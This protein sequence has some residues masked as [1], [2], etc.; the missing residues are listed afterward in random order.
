MASTHATLRSGFL[1]SVERYPQRPA[2]EVAGEVLTYEELH[3]RAASL[4]ATIE[5]N[6]PSGGPALTAVL[7][8][9]SAGAFAGVLGALLS[10]RGYVPLNPRFPA[11]RTA[12]MLSRSGARSL[13][14]DADSVA[15]LD[16]LLPYAE[17]PL[18]VL[19]AD[20]GDT[21]TLPSRFPRHTFLPAPALAEARTWSAGDV[22]QD[23]VAYLLFTSGSTGVPKGVGVVHRNVVPFVEVMA[24]RYGLSEHDRLSQTFDLTFDLSVFDMFLAWERGACLCCPSAKELIKP[25]GFIREA[26]LSIWFSVPS[27]GVFMR[28]LGMLKPDSYPSLRWSLFCGEPLPVEVAQAWAGA[29]PGSTVENL[30]GPTEATIACTV[31]RWDPDR[32]RAECDMG[33]VPIGHPFGAMRALVADPDGREVAPGEQG[34]L[35][36]TGPQVTP[37]YWNDPERTAAAFMVPPGRDEVHYRTGDRVRRPT[38]AEAPI[39]YLGRVDHQIK[40]HGHRVELGEI[41]AVLRE[42]SGVD[43]AIAVGW[44]RTAS[45]ASGIVAFLG[46]PD[47]DVAALR[48]ALKSRLPDYMVPR[49]LE[50]LSELPLN[51][52]GKFDRGA[53]L[54]LLEE[55]REPSAA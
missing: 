28:R 49:R 36:M 17:E 46:D 40:I 2:L 47:V 48:R 26:A 5:A 11:E 6:V 32:S 35:L 13:V 8:A 23:A 33:V 52:N 55:T 39:S 50:L 10:G 44:P 34:E 16:E 4:A 53:L 45:G 1:A 21:G 27:T 19:L 30:Y 20:T 14:V 3:G 31:Y 25:G 24:D 42:E 22:D 9:R 7:G 37:G 12:S 51:A 29:A 41:E 43:A 15:L 38:S 18:L 54:S